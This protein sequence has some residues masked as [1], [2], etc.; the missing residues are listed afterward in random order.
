VQVNADFLLKERSLY[1]I[2]DIAVPE[3]YILVLQIGSPSSTGII[4]LVVPL[5]IWVYGCRLSLHF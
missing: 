3:E 1:F 4:I 2:S 5:E